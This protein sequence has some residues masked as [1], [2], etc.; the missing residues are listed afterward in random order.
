MAVMAHQ[1]L[2]DLA[3]LV[4]SQFYQF[5]SN[6][7]CWKFGHPFRY[8]TVLLRYTATNL[9][10]IRSSAYETKKTRVILCYAYR[11]NTT[12]LP[13]ALLYTGLFGRLYC[14]HGYNV[15]WVPTWANPLRLVW[16]ENRI[17]Y[18]FRYVAFRSAYASRYV[19][20]PRDGL[21]G[22]R[23]TIYN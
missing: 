6:P 7:A 17:G 11:S 19:S 10:L 22:V 23:G 3:Q 5:S 2:S 1:I 20:V 12:S 18:R 21:N 4:N 16:L 13:V 9:A 8:L 15:L 14:I